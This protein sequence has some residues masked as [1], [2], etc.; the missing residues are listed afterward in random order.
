MRS[1]LRV[2]A[3]PVLLVSVTLLAFGFRPA[4][5]PAADVATPAELVKSYDTLADA[6]LAVKHTEENLVRAILAGGWAHARAEHDRAVAALSGGSRDAARASL[7][8][9]AALVAQLGSEGD[10]SVAAVRKRLLEG[11]HHHNASGEAQGIYDEGFVVVTREARKALLDASRAIG[12][13]AASG[14][15]TGL[16]KAWAAAEATVK[17]LAVAER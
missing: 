8:T 11:G 15:R 12:Q 6:I 7:E 13:A 17:S 16:D 10:N 9:L 2:L 4:P 1:A 14:D 5:A 3:L